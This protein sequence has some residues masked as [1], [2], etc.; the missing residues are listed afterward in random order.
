MMGENRIIGY[1]FHKITAAKIIP[2][3]FWTPFERLDL[4]M[5]IR[6]NHIEIWDKE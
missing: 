4:I 5:S 6:L 1:R 3:I 2:D